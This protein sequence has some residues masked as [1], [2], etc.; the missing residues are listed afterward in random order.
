MENSLCVREWI[1]GEMFG[2]WDTCGLFFTTTNW[3]SFWSWFSWVQPTSGFSCIWKA[4]WSPCGWSTWFGFSIIRTLL[5]RVVD[6][7]SGLW[8]LEKIEWCSRCL[9]F[10]LSDGYSRCW[11]SPTYLDGSKMFS[12]TGFLGVVCYDCEFI[13]ASLLVEG[14]LIQI[15]CSYEEEKSL[16]IL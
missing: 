4:S 16:I 12:S 5:S 1:I 8:A 10:G 13:G 9:L 3:V 7:W 14:K 15:G 2:T 6:W 11:S